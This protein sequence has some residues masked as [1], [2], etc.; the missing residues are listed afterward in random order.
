M[1]EGPF[2]ARFNNHKSTVKHEKQASNTT[3]SKHIWDLKA[4]NTACTVNWS[5]LKRTKRYNGFPGQ[6]HFCLIEKLCILSADKHKLLN[7]RSKLI[8]K[9]PVTLLRIAKAYASVWKILSIRWYTL[10]IA[11]G[12]LLIGQLRLSYAGIRWHEGVPY[13]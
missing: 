8:S 2:K 10:T 5:T 11:R 6:C 4:T 13:S 12:T 1:T 9:G 7:N 3:L